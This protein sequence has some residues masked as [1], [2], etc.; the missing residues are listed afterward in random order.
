VN[1]TTPTSMLRSGASFN[2]AENAEPEEVNSPEQPPV[3][4]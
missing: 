3:G 2:P 1:E 4:S